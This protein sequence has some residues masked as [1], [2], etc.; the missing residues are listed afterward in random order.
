MRMNGYKNGKRRPG[1]V[2]FEGNWHGRTL[3]A[4][5]LSHNPAQKEWIGYLD[6]NIYHLPFPYPWRAEAVRSPRAYF[7]TA[8]DALL[9]ERQ[10]SAQA[11]WWCFLLGSDRVWGVG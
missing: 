3:G 9:R 5:M 2:T 7:R 6:P 11:V 1:M 8:M 4:Q 10:L